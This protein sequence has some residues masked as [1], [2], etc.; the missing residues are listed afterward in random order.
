[1]RVV[2]LLIQTL[3]TKQ[4]VQRRSMPRAILKNVMFALSIFTLSLS[5]TSLY[6]ADYRIENGWILLSDGVRLSVT[7]YIPQSD[8]ADTRYP[9]LLEMLPYRKDDLSKAWAHPLYDYFASQGIALAKVDIRGTGSSEGT[10]PGREYSTQEIDDAVEVIAALAE[11]PFSNGNVG[12][13]GI[14]WGGFNAI[15]VAM[16]NPPQLKAILAAH[17]SDDLFRNDVHYTDGL[18]GI[19]EYILS[20]NHMTGFMQSPEYEINENYFENRFDR[21]PWLFETLRNG[22]DNDFWRSGSLRWHYQ[23]LKVPVYLIGGLLDGYRDTLPHVLENASVPVRATLGPWPHAWPNSASPGP[24]WEW[25]EDA[26]RWWKYWLDQPVAKN[27]EF[28]SNSFRFFQRSG[29]AADATLSELDGQ[30]LQTQWPL[31]S[32]KSPVIDFYPSRNNTLQTSSNHFTPTETSLQRIT[33]TGIELG[34]WWGELLPDMSSV[35]SESLVFDSK[36]FETPLAVLGQARV[37]LLTASDSNDGHWVVRLEDIAPDGSV[38]LITGGAVNGQI[39]NSTQQP[40]PLTPGE[41]YPLSIPLR[42]TTWTFQQGHR[43]RLAISNSAFPMFWPSPNLKT[44]RLKIDSVATK[45][46]LPVWTAIEAAKEITLASGGPSN[47]LSSDIINMEPVAG[48]PRRSEIVTNEENGTV[49][50]IRE[51]GL[52]Y[53]MKASTLETTRHTNHQANLENPALSQYTGWAEYALQKL[54]NEDERIVYRTEIK[55]SA[56]ETNFNLE[57]SRILMSGDKEIRRKRWQESI[58]R[59]AH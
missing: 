12:M 4:E 44:S 30:W 57:I 8:S 52:A 21:E 19:D 16:R 47:Y 33:S 53:K 55:L 46:E 43:L 1:M 45:L 2:L 7:Y 38:T 41:F 22:I 18:F 9:V 24:T 31:P 6:A 15:Q 48:S 20:I 27:P 11:Q 34:E 54:G 42:M 3:L 35:D 10:L 56:D 59:K 36:P 50:F 28:E 32:E 25:R 17:A 51:S 23:D 29:N 40:Q 5:C 49:N 26:S 14:S 13:W 58:L 37:N 39:P